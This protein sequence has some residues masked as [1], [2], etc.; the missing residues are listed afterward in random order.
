MS[1]QKGQANFLNGIPELL[2]LRLLS[3]REMY[4]YE[5]TTAIYE[6][7]GKSLDFAEGVIYPLLHALERAGLLRTR[8]RTVNGRPRVYYALTHRGARRLDKTLADWQN[9]VRAVDRVVGG[10]HVEPRLA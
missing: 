1:R 5:L 8:R 3:E 4:G 2:V 9:V 6:S 10:R 7:T